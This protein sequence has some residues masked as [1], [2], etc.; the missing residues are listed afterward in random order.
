MSSDEFDGA[1][2][3]D[4]LWER[5]Q[6]FLQLQVVAG[7]RERA[8]ASPKEGMMIAIARSLAR[9]GLTCLSRYLSRFL[10]AP[11]R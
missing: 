6:Y 3:L 8:R 10:P 2:A 4:C 9:T 11:W 5:V 1:R 7:S